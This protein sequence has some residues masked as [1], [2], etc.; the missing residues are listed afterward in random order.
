M[1]KA[2]VACAAFMYRPAGGRQRACG[3]AAE[4]TRTDF[5]Y[6]CIDTTVW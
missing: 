1:P 5:K 2:N 4:Q 6:Y 3:L